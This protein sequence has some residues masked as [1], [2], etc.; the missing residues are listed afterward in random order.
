[1]RAG[2][3]AALLI[4]LAMPSSA[5]GQSFAPNSPRQARLTVNVTFGPTLLAVTAEPFERNAAPARINLR[6]L[7]DP[8]WAL[9][10]D[11]EKRLWRR[12]DSGLEGSR[13]PPQRP[14]AVRNDRA[15]EEDWDA[16][17]ELVGS[18]FEGY[19]FSKRVSAQI[20]RKPVTDLAFGTTAG[21]PAPP[22]RGRALN[23]A[24]PGR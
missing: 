7:V 2:R 21:R 19:Q 1:M 6:P 16:I 5:L 3:S 13:C 8:P 4:L 17:T 10:T 18:F 23:C 24:R 14:Q 12:A 15:I 20:A 11:G 22:S 9:V